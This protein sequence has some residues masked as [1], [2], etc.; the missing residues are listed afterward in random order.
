MTVSLRKGEIRTQTHTQGERHV[1]MKV[2]IW[3]TQLQANERRR[4]SA[5]H[6]KLEEGHG[7][8]SISQPSEGTNPADTLIL[9]FQPPEL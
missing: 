9:N 1:K 6:Q 3:V 2:G 4:A 8:D 5:D 7:P